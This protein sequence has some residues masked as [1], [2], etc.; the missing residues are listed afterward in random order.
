MSLPFPQSQ[1]KNTSCQ[2]QPGKT[3]VWS[4]QGTLECQAAYP[5]YEEM[6]F[7]NIKSTSSPF[8]T[9]ETPLKSTQAQVPKITTAVATMNVKSDQDV[10]K[11]VT[12]EGFGCAD[13]GNIIYGKYN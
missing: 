12:V 10:S 13:G 7:S 1:P 8:M 2:C 5:V 6:A 9:T 4:S 3:L 11:N